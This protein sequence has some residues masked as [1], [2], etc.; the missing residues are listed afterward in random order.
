MKLSTIFGDII[1]VL[2]ETGE[3]GSAAH[4]ISVVFED[5]DGFRITRKDD[6][7]MY[8]YCRICQ[9]TYSKMNKLSNRFCKISDLK[10][11]WSALGMR[12]DIPYLFACH[13]GFSNFL[14]PIKIGGSVAGNVFGGQFVI[15]R[16]TERGV[17]YRWLDECV[18]LIKK[19]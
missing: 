10:A 1:N 14:I 5:L 13:C 19:E 6:D 9:K 7:D 4:D 17:S 3:T 12:I 8:F 2:W 18:A 16:G 11:S 15:D